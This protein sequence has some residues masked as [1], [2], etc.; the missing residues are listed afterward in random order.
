MLVCTAGQFGGDTLD[1]YAGGGGGQ[2][3]P[4]GGVPGGPRGGGNFLQI[5]EPAL[6]GIAHTTG[7]TYA[8]AAN[9]SQLNKAFA[10]LPKRVVKVRQVDELTVYVVAA[11]ALLAIGALATSKWW[12]RVA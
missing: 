8:R 11:G 7:G 5:D 4:G 2:L 3:I 9:A 6:Q 12:N 10:D 1:P